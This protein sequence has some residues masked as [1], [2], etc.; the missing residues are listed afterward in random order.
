MI[1]PI[2]KYRLQKITKG[3]PLRTGFDAKQTTKVNIK[4]IASC[5]GIQKSLPNVKN[6]LVAVTQHFNHTIL[7]AMI[8][9]AA[10]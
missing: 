9:L 10:L 8:G 6:V 1:V 7:P 5:A 4:H 3:L 2:K